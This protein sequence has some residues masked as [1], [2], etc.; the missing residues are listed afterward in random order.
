MSP[1]LL[2]VDTGVQTKSGKC[3]SVSSKCLPSAGQRHDAH[4]KSQSSIYTFV[5]WSGGGGSER[6]NNIEFPINSNMSM[7]YVYTIKNIYTMGRYIF[8]SN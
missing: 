4:V 3:N 6:T 8:K 5:Y 7:N 2:C 1:P